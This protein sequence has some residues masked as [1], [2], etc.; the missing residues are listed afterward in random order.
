MCNR[1]EC[2]FF[3]LLKPVMWLSRHLCVCVCVLNLPLLPLSD[4]LEGNRVAHKGL[5]CAA[6]FLGD[7]R[8]HLNG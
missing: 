5:N 1:V 8:G 3:P 6:V 2:V 4:W 7:G